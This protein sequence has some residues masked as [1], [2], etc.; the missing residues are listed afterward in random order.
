MSLS[1]DEK[2][3]IQENFLVELES[4]HGQREARANRKM[5]TA[6]LSVSF[7]NDKKEEEVNNYKSDLRLQFYR[8]N[9]YIMGKDHTGRDKWL[10]PTEQERRKRRKGSKKKN[11]T[12]SINFKI[13]SEHV[14]LYSCIVVFAI[15]LGVFISK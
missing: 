5:R 15:A 2:N 7:Q 8:A 13:K 3:K 1:D 14:L 6:S 10:S 12:F 4:E 9:N 11:D